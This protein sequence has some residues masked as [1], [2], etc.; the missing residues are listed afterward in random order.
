MLRALPETFAAPTLIG[1]YGP[2]KPVD[3]LAMDCGMERSQV[4]D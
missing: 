2:M 1:G 3:A 4:R